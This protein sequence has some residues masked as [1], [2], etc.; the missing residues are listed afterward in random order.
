MYVE[1]DVPVMSAPTGGATGNGFG[2]GSEAWVLIILFALIFG[3]GNGFGGRNGNSGSGATDGYVLATDFAT[4][5]RKLDGVNNGICDSTYALNNTVVNGNASLQ[6]TLSQGFAGLNTG[7]VTQGYET[8]GA[9]SD[10]AAQMSNCCCDIKSSLAENKYAF[11]QGLNSVNQTICMSTRDIIDNQNANYRALHDELVAFRLEDK[12]A[13]IAEQQ[14]LIN[15]LQLKASQAE[16]NA[17]LINTL[18][19]TPQPAYLV[20]G[21]NNPY[22]ASAGC[23]CNGTIV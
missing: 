7:M 18:R 2:Y 15:S 19:P 20:C 3:W 21:G 5:E 13:K 4:L 16:Q 11:S 10:V 1:G 8:R 17:Y 22:C 9:I 6:Q 12:N 23:N 14:A